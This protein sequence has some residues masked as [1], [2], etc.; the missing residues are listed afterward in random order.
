MEEWKEFEYGG[1]KYWVSNLGNVKGTKFGILKQRVDLYGYPCITLGIDKRNVRRVHRLVA[2]QFIPNPDNL[3][4]V[5][6]I[7][8]DRKNNNYKNLEWCTHANN[9]K[10]SSQYNSQAY[11]DSKTGIKNGRAI[12]NEEDVWNI[13]KL[14]QNGTSIAEIA[15]VFNRGWQTINHIVKRSSWKH[16]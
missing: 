1:L 11:K 16:I 2:E 13:R 5:N 15:R 4:E 9:I 7:D 8:F 10:H 3:P 12:L 6:H 14:H